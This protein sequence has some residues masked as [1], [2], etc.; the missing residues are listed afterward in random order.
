MP[1]QYPEMRLNGKDALEGL[2]DEQWAARKARSPELV[3]SEYY[4]DLGNALNV[5][6]DVLERPYERI[7][8]VLMNERRRRHVFRPSTTLGT[9]S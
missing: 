5:L 8:S 2:A 4:Q 3:A 6:D 9:R 7:G 1:V